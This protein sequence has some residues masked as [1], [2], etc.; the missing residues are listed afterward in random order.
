MADVTVDGRRFRNRGSVR[1]NRLAKPRALYLLGG[2]P[3]GGGVPFLVALT[4]DVP[5]LETVSLPCEGAT[6]CGRCRPV[7]NLGIRHLTRAAVGFVAHYE[8]LGGFDNLK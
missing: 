8:G 1:V 6:R 2:L 3:A 4:I 7:H 5:T